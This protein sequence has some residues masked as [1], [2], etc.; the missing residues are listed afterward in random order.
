[1][2]FDAL[3]DEV[4]ERVARSEDPIPMR[5]ALVLDTDAW[6]TDVRA[7]A[8]ELL[9]RRKRMDDQLRDSGQGR[10]LTLERMN[11]MVSEGMREA[12]NQLRGPRD[13]EPCQCLQCRIHRY[14]ESLRKLHAHNRQSRT[15][16]KASPEPQGQEDANGRC[17][18]CGSHRLSGHLAECPGRQV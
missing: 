15:P 8:K 2:H 5:T 1:M 3:T 13:P 14:G 18:F 9:E 4:L 11:D 6:V 12:E 7:M 16:E 10:R 17:S